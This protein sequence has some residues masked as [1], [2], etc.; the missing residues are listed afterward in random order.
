M[1][2]GWPQFSDAIVDYYFGRKLA[3]H[4]LWRSQRP[5]SVI[6]GEAGRGKYL[7][8]VDQQRHIGS[9]LS[10]RYQVPD[11][12]S[13]EIVLPASTRAPANQNWQVD[14]IRTY[15]SDQRL[16]LMTWEVG[17]EAYGSHYLAGHPPFSLDRYRSW[18]AAI[19]ALPRPFDAAAVAR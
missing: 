12:D 8:V 9:R 3:Y 5:V 1:I 17:G 14:T 2:D 11:A 4:Y 6:L 19:A 16:Y 15:A 18:L 13:Q 10:V 7:P